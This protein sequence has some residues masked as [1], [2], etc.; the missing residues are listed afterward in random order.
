MASRSQTALF[1]AQL[2][3]EKPDIGKVQVPLANV[4]T[5]K[6]PVFGIINR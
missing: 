3:L 2:F 4:R 5:G 1:Q 6:S